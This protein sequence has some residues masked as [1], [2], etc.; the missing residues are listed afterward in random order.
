V[1]NQ[2]PN[3]YYKQYLAK[4]KVYRGHREI[5]WNDLCYEKGRHLLEMGCNHVDWINLFR[6][7][8]VTGCTVLLEKL[9]CSA[10]PEIPCILLNS[11]FH[12]HI[13]SSLLL[14]KFSTKSLPTTFLRFID[15]SALHISLS[16]NGAGFSSHYS[17]I[18]IL[19]TL[20]NLSIL[21]HHHK[22][23]QH[24]T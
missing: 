5:L 2:Q 1:Y 15:I 12:Y 16:L 10:V 24:Y 6:K 13:Q 23:Q 7:G 18:H 14:S 9:T 17:C 4:K 20:H 21:Q 3:P 19:L 22:Q 11:A 8:L